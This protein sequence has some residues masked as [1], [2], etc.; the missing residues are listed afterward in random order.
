MVKAL[1]GSGVAAAATKAITRART[2]PIT[3]RSS[4]VE[5]VNRKVSHCPVVT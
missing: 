2:E 3:V 4:P 1:T 5:Q